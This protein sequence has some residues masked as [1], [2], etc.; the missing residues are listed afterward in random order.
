MDFIDIIHW[1]ICLILQK[2]KEQV[3]EN[4]Y[5]F[6]QISSDREILDING[7]RI[8]LQYKKVENTYILN[9]ILEKSQD[10][11]NLHNLKF[12]NNS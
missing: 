8:Y 3:E 5:K 12:F 6:L 4:Q 7:L 1:D 2:L 11:L 10:I 9:D